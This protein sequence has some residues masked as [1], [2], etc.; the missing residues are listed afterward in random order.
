M[1][2]LYPLAMLFYIVCFWVYKCLLLKYYART[3]KFNEG[4]AIKSVS[5]IKYGVIFHMVI[6][7]FM[8][9]NS[10]I[11]SSAAKSDQFKSFLEF[12]TALQSKYL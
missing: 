9:T 11:L 2:V 7:S 6:G 8:Y 4:I 3:S 1:P 12:T 5:Y 10:R